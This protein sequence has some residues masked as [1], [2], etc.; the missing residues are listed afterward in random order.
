VVTVV[1]NR[2]VVELQPLASPEPGPNQD[3]LACQVRVKSASDVEGY[4]N[5]LSAGL[6]REMKALV[7]SSTFTDLKA[8]DIWHVE[9]SLVGP[10]Q[11]RI[12]RRVR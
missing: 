6:P 2:A 11:L 10:N 8:A 1:E 12:E 9:A 5:L 3:W 4:R 7:R